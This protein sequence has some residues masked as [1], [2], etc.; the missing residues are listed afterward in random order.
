MKISELTPEDVAR[1]LRID[2]DTARDDDQKEL[3]AFLEA[4]KAFVV[5]YIGKDA[6]ACDAWEDMTIA[7]LLLCQDM[8]DN[9]SAAVTRES[10]A[11][12]PALMRLLGLHD[13]NLI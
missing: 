1:Y 11:Q 7:V 3:T 4:A 5:G 12:N 6:E 2:W 13:Y 8:Y 10:A 9:R